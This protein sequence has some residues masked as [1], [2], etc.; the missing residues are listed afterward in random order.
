MVCGPRTQIEVGKPKQSPPRKHKNASGRNTQKEEHLTQE[1]DNSSQTPTPICVCFFSAFLLG[2]D[3]T[4]TW[5]GPFSFFSPSFLGGLPAVFPPQSKREK[6]RSGPGGAGP[7]GPVAGDPGLE[8]AGA[9]LRLRGADAWPPAEQSAR[10]FFFL[11][12]CFFFS[13]ISSF[14][15][16]IFSLFF[17]GGGCPFGFP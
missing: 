4:K 12:L 2:E 14:F 1:Q 3:Q 15:L 8:L 9:H 6:G 11:L 16:L 7:W 10:A 17:W 13:F 5:I